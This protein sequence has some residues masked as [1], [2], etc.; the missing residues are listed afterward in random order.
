MATAHATPIG[1]EAAAPA[2]RV[3]VVDDEQAILDLVALG[4]RYEGFTVQTACEG[5]EALRLAHQ[6]DPQL[7]IL[8]VMLPGLDGFTLCRSLR[9]RGTAGIIMLTAKDAVVDRIHGLELGADDYLTKPFDFRELVARVRA[10][11]RRTGV[12]PDDV[13]RFAG[14]TLNRGTREVTHD[15]QLVELTPREFALLE[16]FLSHPRQ[17]LTRDVILTRVWGYEFD[18]ESK[19]VDVYVSYLREKLKDTPPTLIQTVRGIGYALRGGSS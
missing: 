6:F 1:N 3:L 11:L 4:L 5:A 18:G 12:Q 13:L 9:A 10:V 7:A 8:D 19:V 2:V 16:L 15:G 14:I 17:V